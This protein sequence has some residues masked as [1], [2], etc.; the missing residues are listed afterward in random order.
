MRTR[1]LRGTR[2]Q[3]NGLTLPAGELSIDEETKALRLH[4]NSTLG[5]F[6]ILGTRAVMPGETLVAGDSTHGF[7]GQINSAD[8]ID[9][10]T[11]ANAV[12]LSAGT[13]INTTSNWLKFSLAGK[14]LYT[15]QKH[16][17]S[18]A[19]WVDI[20]IAGAVYGTGDVGPGYVRSDVIQDA[21]V[22]INGNN[23][24]VRLMRGLGDSYP[25]MHPNYTSDLSYSRYRSSEFEKMLFKVHQFVSTYQVGENWLSLTNTELDLENGYTLCQE[26]E[27]G[28]S[29]PAKILRR[30]NGTLSDAI[31]NINF[32]SAF[33]TTA[34]GWRPVLELIV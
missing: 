16:L 23:Y 12:G 9:G 26:Y 1:F 22:T 29:S 30:G 13:A 7:Y 20:Y 24:I 17:R 21:T 32:I 28:T 15:P 31:E 2:D 5:G 25:T 19:K 27:E 34:V 3:N 8:F 33:Y 18:G 11:L 4:D 14:T 6:E 10:E